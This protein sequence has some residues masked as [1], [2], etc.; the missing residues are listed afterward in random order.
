M[1]YFFSYARADASPYLKKFYSDLLEEV[2]LRVGASDSNTIGFKDVRSIPPGRRWPE[3][4]VEALQTCKVFV[5]LHTP[6]YFGRDGCGREF[7]AITLRNATAKNKAINPNKSHNI[8]P[9][10]WI[11]DKNPKN[12]P[13]EISS[14]QLTS[15][16]F[17][18][19]YNKMGMLHLVRTRYRK[20][21]Y[22]EAVNEIAKQI[23][24]AAESAPLPKLESAPVW[25]EISPLFPLAE[26]PQ[27]KQPVGV[28]YNRP[29]RPPRYA[30][31]VWVVGTRNELAELRSVDAYDPDDI[32][33]EWLPFLPDCSDPARLIALDAARE[34]KLTYQNENFLYD[35][36]EFRR[37]IDK[38]SDDYTPVVIVIDLWTLHIDRYRKV[39]QIF[40]KVNFLNCSVMVPWNFRDE[41]T[42]GALGELKRKLAEVFPIQFYKPDSPF[43]FDGI[44]DLET[45]KEQL[46]KLLTRYAADINRSLSAARTLPER[47]VFSQLPQLASTSSDNSS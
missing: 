47:T 5:Y 46:A 39:I 8:L 23:C 36:E 24:C 2:R 40:D 44:K 4:I 10:Y 3:E 19:V 31:F 26:A 15:E 32:A 13:P 43:L 33:E 17:G 41:E 27:P 28:E 20:P 7:A 18:D 35:R 9:I 21:E 30:R 6:T 45:F 34:A 42:T 38:W 29:V 37:L 25:D 22:W 14:I 12:V 16:A 1:I 11:G